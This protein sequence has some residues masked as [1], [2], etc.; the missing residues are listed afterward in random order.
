MPCTQDLY[1]RPEDNDF[2]AQHIPNV[3]I[4]P[5]DS[6]WGHCVANPGNDKNFEVA[7]DKAVNDLLNR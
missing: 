4:R 7:L 1:F 5:Y 3:E 6:A 2:E